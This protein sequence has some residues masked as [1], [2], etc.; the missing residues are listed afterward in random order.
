MRRSRS[1]GPS[2]MNA[3]RARTVDELIRCFK[4]AWASGE[5]G[6]VC[7]TGAG[8][9]AFCT[10]GDQKQRAET[11]DYGPSESGLFE[12]ETL[13]R[14]DPRDPQA[15]D[16]GGE[17]L[18]DRRRPRAARA[19][20]PDDRRRHRGVR[21]DRPAG[22]LVR[23][24]LRHRAT[25]RASSGEKR[26]R[27]IWFLCRRY[28]AE[29]AERWGLVNRGRAGRRAAGRGAPLGRR[30]PG[31]LPDRA[32]VPQA[33]V[34]RRHRAPRR[35]RAARVHRARAV[36]RVRGGRRRA[37]ARSREKRAP[38]F[39]PLPGAGLGVTTS[40]P[41]STSSRR[42]LAEIHYLGRAKAML[43]W[44]ERTMMPPGGSRG[45]RGPD[46]RA[47]ARP[48]R[49]ARLATSSG[50][51]SRSSSRSAR[52]SA[53]TPTRRALIRVA[54]RDHEKARARPDRAARRDRARRA[55]SPSRHGA[56]R[57]RALRLRA[58][59]PAP[60]AQRL[61]EAPLRPLLRARGRLRP[62][63]RR[64]RAGHEDGRDG[65]HP[66]RPE[67]R[68]AAARRRASRERAASVDDSFLR[69]R[70][71]PTSS[72][73]GARRCWA[74]C[75]CRPSSWRL[76]ET[77]HPFQMSLSPTD[78]RL[79]TR[80]DEQ[81]P[82]GGDLRRAPRVRARPVRERRR[83]GARRLAARRG[84]TRSACTSRRAACGRTWSGE[85]CRSGG[86]STAP[87]GESF[88]DAAR[89]RRRRRRFY[90]AVNKVAA[91]ADPDRGGRAHL[92]PPH[93]A[94]LRAR[95]GAVR[96]QARAARPAGAP[97][98]S[99]CAHYLGIDVPDDA[100]RRAPGRALGGRRRSATSRPTR[101]AT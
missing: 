92:R 89:R 56:R 25:W 17:R 38:D 15:G 101:S 35:R 10:G 20:R 54:R 40:P 84:R 69:R 8:D 1:T 46:R 28:D 49:E 16:R 44:D 97:G 57:K 64:L 41:R 85:A 80:Y 13:H 99:A 5:V 79:T 82:R 76:D 7:L 23:R 62:A 27:E 29:T 68:A 81:R 86:A 43:D 47:R 55:R 67:G 6:V 74:R 24:R 33:V 90:R 96:R 22:R 9:R 71:P 100:A 72:A 48:P 77:A 87:F 58:L 65:G 59:P 11:G 53:T 32:A 34:Q 31:A 18:R 70:F 66:R 21:P 94:A 61:P 14:A 51:C 36:R 95:A 2:G 42:R 91:V 37:C 52:S 93:P 98:T 63:A 88:P 3:F 78:V 12:V 30:D 50:A 75:R 19:L 39:A 60:R 45:A 26:A 73:R 4:R 83:P